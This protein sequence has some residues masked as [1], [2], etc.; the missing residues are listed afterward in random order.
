MFYEFLRAAHITLEVAERHLGFN[1][2]KLTGVATGV[3]ILSPERR[4]ERIDITQGAR[5]GLALELA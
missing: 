4:P 2:P 1:H 3:R 5:E